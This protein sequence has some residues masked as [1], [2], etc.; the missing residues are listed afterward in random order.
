MVLLT[1]TK[2]CGH[3]HVV[4]YSDSMRKHSLGVVSKLEIQ[5]VYECCSCLTWLIRPGHM[6]IP[7]N[8]TRWHGGHV[9]SGQVPGM[10]PP[11]TKLNSSSFLLYDCY[12]LQLSQLGNGYLQRAQ[13]KLLAVFPAIFMILGCVVGVNDCC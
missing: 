8:V 6:I 10:M 7:G 5:M 12:C 13:I 11:P 2:V 1:K 9:T 4:R 3:S